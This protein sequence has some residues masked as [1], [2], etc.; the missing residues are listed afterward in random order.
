VEEN[1]E[2][3]AQ[4]GSMKKRGRERYLSGRNRKSLLNWQK[5]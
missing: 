3:I 1:E 2:R 4:G 5:L